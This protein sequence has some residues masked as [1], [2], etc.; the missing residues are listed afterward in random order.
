[1]SL[2]T[3]QNRVL[4]AVDG[5]GRTR[6]IADGLG[7]ALPDTLALL[8]DLRAQGLVGQTHRLDWCLTEDGRRMLGYHKMAQLEA[9]A[10]RRT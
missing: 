3:L 9:A 10:G 8:T 4:E 2:T 7:L 1:M 6:H 5:M